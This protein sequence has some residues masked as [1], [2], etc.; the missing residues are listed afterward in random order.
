M[1]TT[2][3]HPSPLSAQGVA[4]GHGTWLTRLRQAT[5]GWGS[6]AAWRSTWRPHA[7]LLLPGVAPAAHDREPT[8]GLAQAWPMPSADAALLAWRDWCQA[9]AG[10]RCQLALSSAWSLTAWVDAQAAT[11]AEAMT[12]ASRQWDHYLGVSPDA[13][14]RDGLLR[15]TRASDG[16][17]VCATPRALVD[18]VQAIAGHHGVTLVWMGPWWT[19]GVQRWMRQQVPS[20]SSHLVLQEPAW[21][22]HW[23]WQGGELRCWGQASSGGGVDAH[24]VAM[25]RQGAAAEPC[26]WDDASTQGLITGARGLWQGT[27][28]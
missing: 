10:M 24:V 17:L 4:Q 9:H 25:G 1:N 5:R 14:Q 27:R 21:H 19:R 11:P 18:D 2:S 3:A 15:A 8:P 7:V 12:L 13:L 28:P 6:M 23:Q 26:V 16:W 22:V 20:V